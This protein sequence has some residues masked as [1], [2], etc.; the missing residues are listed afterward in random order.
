MCCRGWTRWTVLV[1]LLGMSFGCGG[2][3]TAPVEATL[4]AE[5]LKRLQAPSQK[6]PAEVEDPLVRP[7]TPQ[8]KP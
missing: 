1:L 3:P 4:P 2:R 6:P 5:R 7:P 8:G